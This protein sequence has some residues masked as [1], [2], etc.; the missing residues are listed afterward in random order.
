MEADDPSSDSLSPCNMF[1]IL[2]R[3]GWKHLHFLFSST[4]TTFKMCRAADHPNN[5]DLLAL[6]RQWL[7]P[8]PLGEGLTGEEFADRPN[9]DHL[10]ALLGEWLAPDIGPAPS[11]G[12]LTDE[13]LV[14]LVN[15]APPGAWVPWNPGSSI[16]EPPAD[17]EPPTPDIGHTLALFERD[18]ALLER[19]VA[20]RHGP[21]LP[22]GEL[23]IEEL[24]FAAKDCPPGTWELMAPGPLTEREIDEALASGSFSFSPPTAAAPSPSVAPAVAVLSYA[25]STT[26]ASTSK[27]VVRPSCGV[28]SRLWRCSCCLPFRSRSE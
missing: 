6:Q 4:H 15:G 20:P 2:A 24:V 23:S 25:S 14:G 5:D 16:P 1:Q 12:E 3:L 27:S 17:V 19:E 13:E 9:T 28:V 10:M 22:G 21:G 11:G 7:G 18:L 26:S 8:D